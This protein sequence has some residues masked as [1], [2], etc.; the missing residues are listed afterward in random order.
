MTASRSA[1]RRSVLIVLAV[2]AAVHLLAVWAVPR[3]IMARVLDRIAPPPGAAPLLPPRADA[4]QRAIVMPSPDLLYALCGYDLSRGP[5]R[6]RADPAAGGYRGYWSIAL[7]AGNSDNLFV[8]N[9]GMAAGRPVDLWVTA[10]E[11]TAPAPPGARRVTAAAGRGLL[12]MRVLATDPAQ[13][14]AARRTLRC[15]AGSAAAL[16]AS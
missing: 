3:V 12:L 4:A 5:L 7:Y 2:A 6:V 13:A 15:D 1:W 16:D 11:E 8:F 9:D 10:A 14:E